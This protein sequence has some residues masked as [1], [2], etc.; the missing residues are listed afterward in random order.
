MGSCCSAPGSRTQDARQGAAD[1]ARWSGREAS[2]GLHSAEGPRGLS[3]PQAPPP[4]DG[5]R[6]AALPW[7]LT[8]G[9][10]PGAV[11][12]R[13][14][15]LIP[16]SYLGERRQGLQPAATGQELPP[17]KW[18]MKM[19]SAA[20]K[21]S[22]LLPPRQ[23]LPLPS[24]LSPAAGTG[25]SGLSSPP[26]LLPLHPLVRRAVGS[27][28][29]LWCG[30]PRP[31]TLCRGCPGRVP[32]TWEQSAPVT[33][34]RTPPQGAGPASRG[35]GGWPHGAVGLRLLRPWALGP[36]PRPRRRAP[37]LLGGDDSGPSYGEAHRV[38]ASVHTEHRFGAPGPLSPSTNA[39]P[40]PWGL[41]SQ[42]PME[43]GLSRAP[44][45]ARVQHGAPAGRGR[46]WGLVG[47]CVTVSPRA[48]CPPWFTKGEVSPGDGWAWVLDRTLQ[49]AYRGFLEPCL[50]RDPKLPM[51]PTLRAG[52]QPGGRI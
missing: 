51:W 8:A 32:C 4:L 28:A 20:G 24:S 5:A 27:P 2:V 23:P 21:P 30:R 11:C 42:R 13:W 39:R 33:V 35:T 49:G 18:L 47:A 40:V 29:G 36:Q 6:E 38:Q 12:A 16:H 37:G 22:E 19:D 44:P 46:P 25:S 43:G 52:D 9:L 50:G 41:C 48:P 1:G 7:L 34:D 15:C 10:E 45:A 3:I 31:L 26:K 17:R 14:C